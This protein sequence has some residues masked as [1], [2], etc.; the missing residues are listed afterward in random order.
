MSDIVE[1][2]RASVEYSRNFAT[3]KPDIGTTEFEHIVGAMDAMRTDARFFRST[4]ADTVS[5]HDPV[6]VDFL[7]QP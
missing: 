4:A 3:A 2:L 1:R 6:V 5:D 7:L